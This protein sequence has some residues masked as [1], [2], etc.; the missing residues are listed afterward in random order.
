MHTWWEVIFCSPPSP[1]T[2]TLQPPKSLSGGRVPLRIKRV[3]GTVNKERGACLRR[4]K[5]P[6]RQFFFFVSWFWKPVVVKLVSMCIRCL[7]R[8]CHACSVEDVSVFQGT[9]RFQKC[10]CH[11]AACCQRVGHGYPWTVGSRC[12]HVWR[13]FSRRDNHSKCAC[14]TAARGAASIPSTRGVACCLGDALRC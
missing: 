6:R 14:V 4:E 5:L 11:L 1:T 7:A 13:G 9:H 12:T 8:T 3:P 2:H 10:K